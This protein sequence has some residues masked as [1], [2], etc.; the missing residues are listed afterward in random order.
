VGL[1]RGVGAVA[2]GVSEEVDGLALEAEADV[3]VDRRSHADVGMSQK[4]LDDHEF[5]ALLQE[6]GRG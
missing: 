3:G 1:G 6:Q 2:E 5:D 4:F